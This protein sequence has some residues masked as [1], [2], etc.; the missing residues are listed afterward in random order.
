MYLMWGSPL[1]SLQA[2]FR[3]LSQER[4]TLN[5]WPHSS[6]IA[7]LPKPGETWVPSAE[8]GKSRHH[9]TQHLPCSVLGGR[10]PRREGRMTLLHRPS[11][12]PGGSIAL[13]GLSWPVFL[14]C[15][16]DIKPHWCLSFQDH[17][18]PQRLIKVTLFCHWQSCRVGSLRTSTC[19]PAPYCPPLAGGG[20]GKGSNPELRP[21]CQGQRK[22]DPSSLLP[23]LLPPPS[24][25][26]HLF[27]MG[28]KCGEQ[29]PA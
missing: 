19:P 9:H 10:A 5:L 8:V 3:R 12:P 16:R 11:G 13:P 23:F 21:A 1:V 17:C 6:V 7:A 18:P 25:L 26:L 14:Y 20:M 28:W 22:L 15:K 29:A 2:T 24:S 27:G 4:K